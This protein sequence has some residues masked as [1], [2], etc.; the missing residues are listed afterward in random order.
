MATSKS[1]IV[2]PSNGHLVPH[3][4]AGWWRRPYDL[5]PIA[6]LSPP[7]YTPA[8]G[9]LQPPVESIAFHGRKDGLW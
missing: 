5:E 1:L 7:L 2:R 4:Y 9:L 3:N 8:R 6:K